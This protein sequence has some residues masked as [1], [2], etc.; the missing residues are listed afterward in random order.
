MHINQKIAFLLSDYSIRVIAAS[1]F[2]ELAEL[3]PIRSNATSYGA[4]IAL[5][6]FY[7]THSIARVASNAGNVV[8]SAYAAYHAATDA[9]SNAAYYARNVAYYAALT[10]ARAATNAAN[11][12]ANAATNTDTT[13]YANDMR[14]L[15]NIA[16]DPDR[17]W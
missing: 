8:R 9:A 12:A 16:I 3:D 11:T 5:T 7:Y 14:A 10:A 17:Y 15:I 6:K 2:P 4:H 13:N 1:Y